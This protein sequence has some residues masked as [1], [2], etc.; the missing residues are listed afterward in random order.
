MADQKVSTWK[1]VLAAI[2]DFLLVF[3]GGGYVIALVTG[4]TTDGGFQ[5]N[6]APA[7]ILFAL[8]IAYFVV[9]KRLGGTLFK[10][11]FGIA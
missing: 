1:V 5:L 2:L 8:V 10:R 7:L 9:M 6:G 11:L 4:G 3:L